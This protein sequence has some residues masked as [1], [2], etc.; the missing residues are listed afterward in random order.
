MNET[1]RLQ[2]AHDHFFLGDDHRRNERRVW[3]VI[4]LTA[5]M[6]VVE[7][8][9]GNLYGSMALVADGWHMSTH[10]GALLI[11]ALAY[12]YARKHANDPRFTFGTGKLGDLAGFASAVALAL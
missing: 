3:L 11:A 12:G 5:S 10:A 2:N 8:V 9:A 7:I 6:M 4:A 1:L